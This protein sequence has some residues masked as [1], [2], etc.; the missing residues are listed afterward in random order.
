MK[1]VMSDGE[2][3]KKEAKPIA[4]FDS[5]NQYERESGIIEEKKRANI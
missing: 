2:N 3:K 1:E 5:I 4:S